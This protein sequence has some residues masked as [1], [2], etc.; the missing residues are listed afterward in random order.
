M[1]LTESEEHEMKTGQIS[2]QFVNDNIVDNS[3]GAL[4]TVEIGRSSYVNNGQDSQNDID[5]F[6]ERPILIEEGVFNTNVD[7]TYDIWELLSSNDRIRSKLEKFAYFQGDIEITI[8]ISG[9][10][11][12]YG[13]ILLS[14]Q[15]Y[16]T[17]NKCLE[18]SRFI[19]SGNITTKPLWHN[20]LSQARDCRILD[21]KENAPVVMRIPFISHKPMFRLFNE[22]PAASVTSFDDFR[23]AGSLYLS[24]L[25]QIDS[26]SSTPSLVGYVIYA[27]FCN[28]KL[29][30]LTG[31]HM[32]SES[33]FVTEGDE[34]SEGP[35][36]KISSTIAKAAGA[37]SVVVPELAPFT[38]P[39]SILA[40]G[41][42]NFASYFGWARPI[43]IE[44]RAVIKPDGF[45]N[46][47]HVISTDTA[48]SI[49]LDPKGAI[50]VSQGMFGRDHDEMVLANIYQRPAYYDSFTWSPADVAYETVLY[51]SVLTPSYGSKVTVLDTYIQPTP[52]AFAAR[53]FTYWRGDIALTFDFVVSS[54]HRGKVAIVYEPNIA[55]YTT[56]TASTNMNEQ[57]IKILDLQEAQQI[58]VCGNWASDRSWRRVS[59]ESNECRVASNVPSD[60]WIP[61]ANGFIYV[62][63]I[64][65]LQSPDN[66]SIEVN[67][68]VHGK[69]FHF[70]VPNADHLVLSRQA[71][72]SESEVVD[73]Y[74]NTEHTCLELNP[75]SAST[76]NIHLTNFG[77]TI[78][79]FRSL[80]KRYHQFWEGSLFTTQPYAITRVPIYPNILSP[81]GG[82]STSSPQNLASYLRYAYLGMRGSYRYRVRYAM[83]RNGTEYETITAT[84][85]TPRSSGVTTPS[86]LASTVTGVNTF[87]GGITFIP[88]VNPAVELELPF[89][90]ANLWVFAQETDFTGTNS[91]GEFEP[92]FVRD[93]DIMVPVNLEGG[94]STL[95]VTGNIESC[96]GEDFNLHYF[97]GAPPYSISA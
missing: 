22:D 97:L 48:K 63:P 36:T 67:V 59:P 11:F 40:T 33:H 12:H 75:S 38:V 43:M 88:S 70:A 10:P 14:Y 64:T 2:D 96:S 53:P 23:N 86:L 47:S 73:I 21:V 68:Y 8:S 81:L 76:D 82:A 52:L 17:H 71:W 32:V 95:K 27:N 26:V 55:Q 3:G 66:S 69:D 90:T 18:S 85:R 42:S 30:T 28:V 94:G 80:L 19:M 35:I 9:T 65:R 83:P 20:Y 93:A 1:F 49:R 45:V 56:I 60:G 79:S 44:N 89:Y 31:T 34:Q 61:Y 92:V 77:E 15:P 91:L 84:L 41:I 57:Y 24:T 54:Y 37:L 29:G 46:G 39:A 58:T 74:F 6:L 87:T 50:E 16:P 72:V 62:V 4:D 13:K 51:D 7:I 78:F 5:R 25:N